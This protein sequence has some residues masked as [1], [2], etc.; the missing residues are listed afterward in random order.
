MKKNPS[1]CHGCAKGCNITIDHNREKNRDD[2]IYRFR[3]RLN[4]QVNGYFICDEGRLSYRLENENRLTKPRCTGVAAS[5]DEAV[6]RAKSEMAK[7]A[8]IVVMLSPS[9]SLEQ[10]MAAKVFAREKALRF[11]PRPSSSS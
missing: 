6:E 10:V 3:P 5:L 11:L 1:I 8:K 9:M 2:I 7:A 4:G